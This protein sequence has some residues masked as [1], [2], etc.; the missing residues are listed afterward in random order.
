MVAMTLGSACGG[1]RQERALSDKDVL[2]VLRATG[3]HHLTAFDTDIPLVILYPPPDRARF[4]VVRIFPSAKALRQ[5]EL[6]RSAKREFPQVHAHD[7][8]ACNVWIPRLPQTISTRRPTAAVRKAMQR[9]SAEAAQAQ[10][11]IAAALER[12]CHE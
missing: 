8:T 5:S 1:S 3:Y 2:S 12:R 9:A 7:V 11:E 4:V 6:I 10:K